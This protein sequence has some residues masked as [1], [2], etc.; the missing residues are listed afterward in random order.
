M[1]RLEIAHPVGIVDGF[2]CPIQGGSEI[3]F[4]FCTCSGHLLTYH[5]GLLNTQW[6][7]AVNWESGIKMG[8]LT[9]QRRCLVS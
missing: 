7:S 6:R 5:K 3:K 9:I 8:V 2:F 1:F 4:L